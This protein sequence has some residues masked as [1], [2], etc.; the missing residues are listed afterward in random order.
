[1]S[2]LEEFFEEVPIVDLYFLELS[3]S[4][5]IKNYDEADFCEVDSANKQEKKRHESVSLVL[6]NRVL[7]LPFFKL[8]K[9]MFDANFFLN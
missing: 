2:K 6:K 4:S 3:S 9:I 7:F 1:M 5:D 8:K